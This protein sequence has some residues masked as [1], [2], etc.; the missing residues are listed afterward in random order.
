MVATEIKQ[1]EVSETPTFAIKPGRW[2]IL[3]KSLPRG[4]GPVLLTGIAAIAASC[5][6]A[7]L[8]LNHLHRQAIADTKLEL[9]NLA[10][11]LARYTENSLQAI[12][13]LE[14]GVV[15]MVNA[16]EINS[17]EQFNERISHYRIHRELR[18]LAQGL[19][20]VEA[21]F[22]TNEVGLTI[23]STRA[24]PQQVFSIAD[25][26][27]FR[28]I[29]DDPSRQSYLAPAARNFQTGTWNIYLTRRISTPDGKFL[30]IAGAGIGLD[31]MESFLARLALAPA[32]AIA[33][34]RKDGVLLAR[35]PRATAAIGQRSLPAFGHVPF[36]NLLETA[37][38][39]TVEGVS[40][41]DG[42]Q[43]VTAVQALAGYPV[44]ITVS[45]K[46]SDVLSSWRR[47]ALFTALGL[48]L[49]TSL[50]LSFAFQSIRHLASR[51]LLE[52][53][54]IK[55]GILEEQRRAEAKISHLAHHDALT[56]LANRTLFQTR[57]EQAIEQ[58]KRGEA[59]AVLC[60]DLDHF[61]DVNDTL[62]HSV[63]DRLLQAVSDRLKDETRASDTIARLGGDEFAV[64]QVGLSHQPHD[65]AKLAQR[66]VEALTL[67]FDIDGHHLTVG[68]S[69]GIAVAPG[70][71]SDTVQLLKNADLALYRAKSDGRGRFRFFEAEM[72]AHAQ[73]RRTLLIDLRR[74]IVADEFELFYQ[75]KID[76]R[77]RVITGFEALLRWRHPE[78]G[79]I[80]PDRF[81]A[82]AEETGLI[83]P[84]GEWVLHRACADAAQWPGHIALAVNL[85]PVQFTSGGLTS[86][87]ESAI[88][89][90]GL[91]ANR[92][93]LEITETV[94]L[95]DTDATLTTLHR[96]RALGVAIALD[97]FGTGYSSL[98][99]LQRFPFNRVKID[100]SFVQSLGK[101]K[102]S[103]AIVQSVITLCKALDMA[104][105]AEGV[106]TEEQCR[107]LAAAGCDEGQGY[108]FGRP[109]PASSQLVF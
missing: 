104:I 6:V 63:G 4:A 40:R 45:R 52:K 81:I 82:L 70:D 71:G 17:V 36:A 86:A 79:M 5:L 37:D 48:F 47:Q 57:L 95:R 96:L 27:H 13:L 53:T 38:S 100:K 93:E 87:V 35:Y 21:L 30:G 74:A 59:C 89:T 28:A 26:P 25:R 14:E 106:E 23:A 2:R 101:R 91:S 94:L 105:T 3:L 9:S 98:G 42:N 39:A 77:T 24:W 92:L 61:K 20:D 54:R 19:P 108:L 51:D 7:G 46:T 11:V 32:S 76:M 72:N 41:I 88:Q 65:H 85:S 33:I 67:P 75:P 68:V 49:V 34:W 80:M 10:L 56:G 58:A 55:M 73:M 22:L 8:V 15:S 102:E 64:V 31:R 60:L 90:S 43:R 109:Q 44:A 18:A 69:I 1:Y 29:R 84:L 16:L 107:I 83:I 99:Y 66:L 12:E 97:D 62:G 103:D 78:Q 50:V